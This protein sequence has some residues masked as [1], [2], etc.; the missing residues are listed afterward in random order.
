M[1]LKNYC[2]GE[3]GSGHTQCG[4]GCDERGRNYQ[5]GRTSR[6]LQPGRSERIRTSPPA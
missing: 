6:N 3:T 5:P 4:K 2:I 1:S